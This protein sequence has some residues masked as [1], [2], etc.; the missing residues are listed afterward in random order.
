M[1]E[2]ITKYFPKKR[3][4]FFSTYLDT[5]WASFVGILDN[6]EINCLNLSVRNFGEIYSYLKAIRTTSF[7][8]EGVLKIIIMAFI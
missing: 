7:G 3:N 2:E 8:S 1:K 5:K 6:K 4:T